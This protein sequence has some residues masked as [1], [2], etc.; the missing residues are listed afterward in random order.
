MI[1][2][3]TIYGS[4]PS[5]SLDRF[6]LDQLRR[7]LVRIERQIVEDQ[8]FVENVDDGIARE[9][10]W[11]LGVVKARLEQKQEERREVRECIEWLVRK[12]VGG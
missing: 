11:K 7:M 10:A 4:S 3:A 5:K 9:P 2:P 12:P 8:L 6:S 1:K